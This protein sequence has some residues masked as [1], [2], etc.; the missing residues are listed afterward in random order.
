M[1]HNLKQG[2][3][4]VDKLANPD[5]LSRAT[6]INLAEQKEVVVHHHVMCNPPQITTLC[7]IS[8]EAH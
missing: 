4:M 8:S 1:D 3:T 7:E 2:Q 6:G 5:I